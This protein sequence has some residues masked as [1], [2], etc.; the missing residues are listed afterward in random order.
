MENVQVLV[1]RQN[2]IVMDRVIVMHV[3]EK[4]QNKLQDNGGIV[5]YVMVVVSVNIVMERVNVH[6]AVGQ[7]KYRS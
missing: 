7:V 1:R 3:M 4:V 6:D 5:V 2:I